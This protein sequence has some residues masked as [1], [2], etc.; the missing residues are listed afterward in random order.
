VWKI[1]P[2]LEFDPWT[3]QPVASRYTGYAT[4][5]TDTLI[6]ALIK[7]FAIQTRRISFKSPVSSSVNQVLYPT[8]LDYRGL[9]YVEYY[10]QSSVYN[11]STAQATEI[12]INT[13]IY[14]T[15]YIKSTINWT[16]AIGEGTG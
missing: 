13:V 8:F 10:G 9:H 6:R 5:P 11:M 15:H 16:R 2:P 12:A 4:Q 14:N 1:S 7:E 3:F